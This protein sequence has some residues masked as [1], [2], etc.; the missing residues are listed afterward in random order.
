[1]TEYAVNE[2]HSFGA[3]WIVVENDNGETGVF[4]GSDRMEVIAHFLKKPYYGVHPK[5]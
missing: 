1:V 3:P 2:L 5:L 4:F